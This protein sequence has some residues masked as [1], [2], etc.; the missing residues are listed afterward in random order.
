MKATLEGK[1]VLPLHPDL[2]LKDRKHP[3]LIKDFKIMDSLE[4]PKLEE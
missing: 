2:N 4:G 1:T 3:N